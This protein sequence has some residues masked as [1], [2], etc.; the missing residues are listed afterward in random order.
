MRAAVS[1]NRRSV[2][3]FAWIG[4][5]RA[6]PPA[7]N[8]GESGTG[9]VPGLRW[10]YWPASPCCKADVNQGRSATAASGSG[11]V[12]SVRF[13]RPRL[14]PGLQPEQPRRR[15]L[16]AGSRQ[17]TR[18]VEMSIA[19]G[20]RHPG[21]GS[22]RI[23]PGRPRGRLIVVPGSTDS[24]TELNPVRGFR[25]RSRK[26]SRRRATVRHATGPQGASYQTRGQDSGARIARR[27]T[28][29]P[30]KTTVTTPEPTARSA[31]VAGAFSLGGPVR[32]RAGPARQHPAA[33]LARRRAR[34]VR[35]A[36]GST[37]GPAGRRARQK[38]PSTKPDVKSETPAADGERA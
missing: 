19:L 22:H 13:L 15:L 30:G 8:P 38:Q 4:Y 20:R 23:R 12:Q 5:R 14:E 18:P 17:R 21:R 6:E 34:V 16:R 27:R 28:D 31:Q 2:S 35:D 1:E 7:A 26:S 9:A 25:P 37:G 3:C 36:A 33:R 24:S 32:R 29:N 11:L 10:A